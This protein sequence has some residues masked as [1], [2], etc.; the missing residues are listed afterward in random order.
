V[1]EDLLKPRA[2]AT[3]LPLVLVLLLAAAAPLGGC[4]LLL[5][6]NLENTSAAWHEDTFTGVTFDDVFVITQAQ[7]D[8]DYQIATSDRNT[9][10]IET[11]WDYGS[12]SPLNRYLQRERVMVEMEALDE[13]IE[14][15]LRVKRQVKERQGLLHEE[16][17]DEEGWT[18]GRDDVE[19]AA[20]LFERIRSSFAPLRPSE[21]FYRKRMTPDGSDGAGSTPP[22]DG[23]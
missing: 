18:D 10:M 14:L 20:V 19:R 3:P 7:L 17:T 9:G 15:R 5:G 11:D 23:A 21:D 2:R 6:P 1:V 22:P 4:F 13:G 16:E 12:L 8:R